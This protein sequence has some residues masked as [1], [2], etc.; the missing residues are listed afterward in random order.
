L[1]D[2][3]NRDKHKN[4]MGVIDKLTT[5]MGRDIVKFAIQGTRLR[6]RLKQEKLSPHYTTN[7]DEILE[8]DIDKNL[9]I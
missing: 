2:N 7:W 3:V 8:I 4:L 5:T 6:W 1:W 9:K